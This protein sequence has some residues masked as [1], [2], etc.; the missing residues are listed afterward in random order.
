[1][2]LTIRVEI[3]Y[4]SSQASISEKGLELMKG[5]LSLDPS[6]RTP[7]EKALDHWWITTEKPA[8]TPVGKMP[9]VNSRPPSPENPSIYCSSILATQ[10][11]KRFPRAFLIEKHLQTF[12]FVKRRKKSCDPNT[13]DERPEPWAGV[14][15]NDGISQC[16]QIRRGTYYLFKSQSFSAPSPSPLAAFCAWIRWTRG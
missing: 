8:P 2:H 16:F 6:K 7:A 5:L 3:W 9:Q 12:F 13:T 1:M 11:S 15:I 10:C 14:T 4:R